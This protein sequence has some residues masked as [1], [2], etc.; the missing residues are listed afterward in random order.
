[1][2]GKENPSG[3][4]VSGHIQTDFTRLKI[5]TILEIYFYFM[6]G[7]SQSL[8]TAAALHFRNKR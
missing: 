8:A 1:M 2:G 3:Y 5:K 6:V 7:V 4:Y